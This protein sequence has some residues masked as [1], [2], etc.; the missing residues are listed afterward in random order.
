MDRMEVV[1]GRPRLNKYG[2]RMI[3]FMTTL[4]TAQL[5]ALVAAAGTWTWWPS[6]ALMGMA[7]TFQASVVFLLASRNPDLLN[8]RG[9]LLQNDTK[10]FDR[11]V[12][13]LYIPTLFLTLITGAVDA[14]RLG[15]S[16]MPLSATLV[17]YCAAGAGFLIVLWSMSVNQHFETTVRIQK[18]RAHQVI[19]NG[20]Y[21]L[22]RQPGYLGAIIV[23]A[24]I[25]PM[26][27]SVYAYIP[28]VVCIAI[29][30]V[31]TRLEDDTLH[32]ELAGYDAYAAEVRHR[33]APFVW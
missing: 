24:A 18:E 28:A 8:A 30:V 10:R 29:F 19:R 14:G 17:A 9:R 11:L 32:R 25:P 26:L 13:R 5:L 3:A 7:A 16:A 20:P 2:W 27:Q 6:Y 33:L 21:R 15:A 23:F 1:A 31:R 22:V 12:L 4:T